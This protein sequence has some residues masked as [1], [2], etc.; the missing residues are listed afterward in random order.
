ML[1]IARFFVVVPV[2]SPLMHLAFVAVTLTQGALLLFDLEWGTRRLLPLFVLQLFAA[3]SGFRLPARRGHYDLLLTSGH[4]WATI[5]SAHWLMSVLPGIVSWLTLMCTEAV[6]GQQ[7]LRSR[8]AVV[9]MLLAST[10]PWALTVPLP[11]LTGGLLILVVAAMVDT[12]VP[13]S[14]ASL[15]QRLTPAVAV[16]LSIAGFGLVATAIASI[17]RGDVRLE[18]GQ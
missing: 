8:Q 11:R 15:T 14:M 10:V 13:W 12:V 6:A 4:R 5:A 7:A 9:A 17:E 3:S 18:S 2:V 1:T 16:S